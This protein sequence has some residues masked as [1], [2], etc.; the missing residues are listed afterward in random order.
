MIGPESSLR[1]DEMHRRAVL[2]TPA[3]SAR[4]CGVE[5]L[6]RRQQ[7]RVDV[8]H[9]P[10]PALRRTTGVS[11]AHE[12]RRGRRC[13]MRCVFEHRLQRALECFAVLAERLVIDHRGRDAGLA[14][15]RKPAGIR[16]GWRGRARSRPDSPRPSP[17]RSAPPCWSRGPR[18][19]S[20]RACGSS[21]E[22]ELAVID[23]ARRVGCA[24]DRPRRAARPSRLRAASTS[25]D[26]RRPC[27]ARP[28][29]SCR[30]RS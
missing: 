22:I 5:A 13:S 8:E 23:D 20:R 27:R 17:P 19:G 15:A 30:C 1:H 4:P 3:A 18:S 21:S 12:T 24:R 7:G 16:D 2:F 6:E 11:S 28:P 9:A 14:R 25:V 10:V 26:A 29:R